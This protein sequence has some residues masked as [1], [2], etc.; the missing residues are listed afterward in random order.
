[1]AEGNLK[2]SG[3]L[4]KIMGLIGRLNHVNYGDNTLRFPGEKKN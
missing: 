3:Q 2:Y 4:L 1:M